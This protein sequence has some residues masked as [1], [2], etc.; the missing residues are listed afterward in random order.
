M[1]GDGTDYELNARWEP[2]TVRKITNKHSNKCLDVVNESKERGANVQQWQCKPIRGNDFVENQRW[3]L[4]YRHYTTLRH[5]STPSD[6]DALYHIVHIWSLH[7]NHSGD[8]LDVEGGLGNKDESRNVQ[9]FPFHN[10]TNQVWYVF[11]SKDNDFFYILDRKL[12]ALDVA[13]G[14]VD[15]NA[16][17]Q[18]HPFHGGDNQKWAIDPA[19]SMFSMRNTSGEEFVREFID[20]I[21]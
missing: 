13:D 1:T 2:S 9:Q 12:R 10:D 3:F 15:D 8:V 21:S 18:V 11:P 19:P 5:P 4:Q 16:N 7:A 6:D 14:S 17:V 20:A